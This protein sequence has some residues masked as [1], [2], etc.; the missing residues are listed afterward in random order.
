MIKLIILFLKHTFDALVYLKY[1]SHK[2]LLV[3]Q[4]FNC[5]KLLYV[6]YMASVLIINYY[7]CD[8]V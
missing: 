8:Y 3:L 1:L 5:K 7:L 4:Y 2:Y 6:H